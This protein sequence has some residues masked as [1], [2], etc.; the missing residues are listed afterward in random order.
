MRTLWEWRPIVAIPARNEADRLPALI[1]SL[2]RQSWAARHGCLH[3]VLV[4]NNSQ[5][6]SAEIA[7]D[8]AAHHA[9]LF[10]DVIEID[11]PA[12]AAHVGSARRFAIERARQMATNPSRA[13]LLTTDADAIPAHTWIDANLH[14]FDAGADMV[15]GQIV[16]DEPEEALLGLRFVQRAGQHLRYMKLA[17]RLSALIDPL[18]Y[19]TWPRHSDHTG[20]SLAVRADVYDAVGGIAALPF[21]EDLAFVNRVRGAG[22]RLRHSLDVRVKVSARL[23]GRAPGGM[24]DCLRG[25]VKSEESGLPH[26]VENPHS[27]VARLRRRRRCRDVASA[28]RLRLCKRQRPRSV[29]RHPVPESELSAHARIESIAPDEPDALPS[30]PVEIAIREIAGILADVESKISVA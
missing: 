29:P 21:R 5:D 12:G 6:A 25:W 19:D 20:A 16:G 1:S 2:S 26:L 14:A 11:F 9:N 24:A 23:D 4:V 17:D 10:V 30:V 15:G 13:V 28:E 18:P 27:I 7:A 8:L 3:V 22:Y